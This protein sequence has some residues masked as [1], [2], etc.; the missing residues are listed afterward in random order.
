V[1]TTDSSAERILKRTIEVIDTSGEAAVRV[2]DICDAAGVTAPI[3]YRAY[4]SRDGL[5]VAAQTERY[6]RSLLRVNEVLRVQVEACRDA[7]EFR[8]V[9][10]AMFPTVATDKRAQF[11]LT[12]LN[13]FGSSVGRPGLIDAIREADQEINTDLAETFRYAK[14]HQWTRNDIDPMALAYWYMGMINGRAFAEIAEGF[15]DLEA[16]NHVAWTALEAVLFDS[17]N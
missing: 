10:K 12:R 9:V 6:K 1:K 17:P 5:I 16:W 11:R 2:R 7:D 3:L 14:D 13:V 15:V 4:G 8:N